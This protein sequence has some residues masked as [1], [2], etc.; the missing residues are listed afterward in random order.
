MPMNKPFRIL[1]L[2]YIHIPF[3]KVVDSDTPAR[4]HSKSAKQASDNPPGAYTLGMLP[5]SVL[6]RQHAE[7]QRLIDDAIR[8][9]DHNEAL[10][11]E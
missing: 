6:R 2:L 7:A 4:P 3:R 9:V 8:P 10:L 11:S 5:S 1:S